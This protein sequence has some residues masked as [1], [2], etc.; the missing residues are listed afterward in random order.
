MGHPQ[1]TSI[2]GKGKINV[3]VKNFYSDALKYTIDPSEKHY[4]HNFDPQ[5][6]ASAFKKIR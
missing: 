3:A 2:S 5:R 4:E 1:A 6:V